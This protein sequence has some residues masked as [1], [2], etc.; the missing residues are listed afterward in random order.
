MLKLF[1]VL[2]LIAIPALADLSTS[3]S[4][5]INGQAV[6]FADS[7]T[8]T[9]NAGCSEI[10]DFI[11]PGFEYPTSAHASASA[12]A[13]YGTLSLSANTG[14]SNQRDPAYSWSNAAFSETMLITGSSGQG[15]A[16]VTYTG[17]MDTCFGYSSFDGLSPWQIFRRSDNCFFSYDHF[18][19]TNTYQFT[20]GVPFTFGANASTGSYCCNIEPVTMTDVYARVSGIEVLDS[21]H[22]P[23]PSF[24]YTSASGT[25][26]SGGVYVPEPSSLLLLLSAV[27]L[28]L[29]RLGRLP[30]RRE[31][32]R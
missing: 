14:V 18:A 1:P 3:A 19:L 25:I 16:E 28:F 7:H 6:Y 17:F 11:D 8:G 31:R 22:R 20:F 10:Q 21:N 2:L 30:L 24:E 5:Q 29:M 4:C 26:Y 12:S 13:G 9:S 32:S 15:Y 27:F 23:L